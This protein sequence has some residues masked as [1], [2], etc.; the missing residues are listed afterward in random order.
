MRPRLGTRDPFLSVTRARPDYPELAGRAHRDGE[1]G[2]PG[3][4]ATETRVSDTGRGG[5]FSK[6]P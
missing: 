3:T 5:R 1:D 2:M 6:L 4:H